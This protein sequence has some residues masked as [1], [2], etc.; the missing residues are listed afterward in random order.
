VAIVYAGLN[1]ACHQAY[2]PV[3]LT[4]I[5]AG[6][7]LLQIIEDIFVG[8][9]AHGRG[10]L[11]VRNTNSPSI[12]LFPK[13]QR[14]IPNFNPE[15]CVPFLNFWLKSKSFRR[16]SCPPNQHNKKRDPSG[17]RAEKSAVKHQ[18]IRKAKAAARI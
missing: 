9:F 18:I 11:C 15:K 7:N 2:A 5:C 10:D 3:H 6:Y 13:F 8:A 12:F 17:T 1:Q 16:N 14:T 4:F